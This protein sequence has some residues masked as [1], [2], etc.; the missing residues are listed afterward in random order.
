[1]LEAVE[2]VANVMGNLLKTQTRLD[3]TKDKLINL[4]TPEGQQIP[5]S[6]LWGSWGV[7]RFL[8]PSHEICIQHGG[9]PELGPRSSDKINVFQQN[10][11]KFHDDLADLK[12]YFDGCMDD[13][14]FDEQ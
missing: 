14:S 9:S 1:M 4:G 12:S 7:K 11:M 2:N 8:T 5:H 13:E 10:L 6:I 3:I